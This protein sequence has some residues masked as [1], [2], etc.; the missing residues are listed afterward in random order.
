MQWLNSFPQGK[1]VRMKYIH[2]MNRVLQASKEPIDEYL[3]G[4]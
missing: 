1:T 2:Q 4:V 3:F